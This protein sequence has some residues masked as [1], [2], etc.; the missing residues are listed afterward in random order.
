MMYSQFQYL[1]PDRVERVILNK[2]RELDSRTSDG[3]HVR[4]LWHSSDNR[5]SVAVRDP[6]TGEAFEL[7]VRRDQSPLDVFHHPFAYA[8]HGG[9]E[10]HGEPVPTAPSRSS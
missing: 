4:L 8:A 7:V 6:K 3:I 2:T 9:V 10:T 1:G 5:V